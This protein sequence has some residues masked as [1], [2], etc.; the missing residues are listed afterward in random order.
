MKNEQRFSAYLVDGTDI[1]NR[2]Q[3]NNKSKKTV[4]SKREHEREREGGRV[5]RYQGGSG[6]RQ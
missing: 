2:E 6:E 5:A 4:E 1:D 3:R